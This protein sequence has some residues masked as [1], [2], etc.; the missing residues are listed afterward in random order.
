L[1]C[2]GF[3]ITV[4]R[5][6]ETTN[7]T[8]AYDFFCKMQYIAGYL[9]KLIHMKSQIT[10]VIASELLYAGRTAVATLSPVENTS[11]KEEL[12]VLVYLTTHFSDEQEIFL[13][14]CWPASI[15]NSAF[16]LQ[17]ADIFVFST[18]PTNVTLLEQLFQQNN[19][20]IREYQNPGYHEGAILALREASQQQWFHTGYD[21]IIRMNADVIL[22]EEYWIWET[23][24]DED[25]D[26]IF[27]DC[28]AFNDHFPFTIQSDFFAYR[29]RA[30]PQDAFLKSDNGHAES[31]LTDCMQPILQSGRFRWL[32]GGTVPEPHCCR[33]VGERSPVIHDHQYVHTCV[34]DIRMR[35]ASPMEIFQ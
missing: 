2:P 20:T 34:E 26:A 15:V 1:T 35:G 31:H 29:P 10:P 11:R 24:H 21:W 7:E 32:Y 16:I 17:T 3:Y 14:T 33:V 22:R 9:R 5:P 12:R 13:R 28:E 18:G 19:L 23:M 27:L 6:S 30:L 8:S 4:T 25:V